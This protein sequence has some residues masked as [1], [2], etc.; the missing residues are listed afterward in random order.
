MSQTNYRTVIIPAGSATNPGIV[1]EIV[2]GKFFA[3]VSATDVFFVRPNQGAVM[4]QNQGRRFGAIEDPGFTN[5]TFFNY[6]AAAVTVNYYAGAVDYVPD[7]AV[8]ATISAIV[9]TVNVSTRNA[10]TYARGSDPLTLTDGNSTTRTGLDGTNARKQIVIH[11]L[12]TS[13]G[14][15][16]IR[17]DAGDTMDELAPG[18]PPW[19]IETNGELI[20]TASG[21]NVN[22]Y[23]AEI[24]YSP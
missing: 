19:T 14:K 21:G 13:T 1:R 23:F 22:L 24:F 2:S 11:N 4:Q 10:G 17:D 18:D 7:A 16:L 6:N 9:S 3:T 12:A 5:L 15:L 20:L 8:F